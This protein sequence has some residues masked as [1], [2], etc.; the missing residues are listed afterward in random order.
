MVKKQISVKG[1]DDE[2]F[3]RFKARAVEAGVPVGE[4]LTRAMLQWRPKSKKHK[5]L[6]LLNYPAKDFEPGTEHLSLEIDEVLYGKKR[7]WQ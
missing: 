4:A 3:T 7:E 2:V 6:N 5:R 1:V